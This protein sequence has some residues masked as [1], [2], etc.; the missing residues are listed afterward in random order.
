MTIANGQIIPRGGT[1]IPFI[2][3]EDS[4]L[5]RF[6]HGDIEIT[7]AIGVDGNVTVRHKGVGKPVLKGQD[8]RISINSGEFWVEITHKGSPEAF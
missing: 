4:E 7:H 6:V 2:V 3:S 8:R 1:P 5:M